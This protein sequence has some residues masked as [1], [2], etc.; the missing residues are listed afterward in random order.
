MSSSAAED[1][2]RVIGNYLSQLS[3]IERFVVAVEGFP[4]YW[5]RN[6]DQSSAEDLVALATDASAALSRFSDVIDTSRSIVSISSGGKTISVLRSGELLVVAEGRAEIVNAALSN[7]LRYLHSKIRCP[8]CGA[9]ITL[10]TVTCPSCGRKLPLGI[11]TCPFCGTRIT[12]LKCPHCSRLVSPRGR[13]VVATRSRGDVAVA[14]LSISVAAIVMAGAL[15]LGSPA[16]LV[17]AGLA[18]AILGAIA[19]LAL[20]TKRYREF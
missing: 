12:Y 13:R 14:G 6:L 7:V 11:E 5:S 3:G 16:V 17:T 8:W 4:T 20:R 15:L 18:V 19:L 1:L 9:D 2:P 10:A